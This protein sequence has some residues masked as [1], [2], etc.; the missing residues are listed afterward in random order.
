MPMA[1]TATYVLERHGDPS[2]IAALHATTLW[3]LERAVLQLDADAVAEVFTDVISLADLQ[4]P[5]RWR[6]IETRVLV[7]AA[8]RLPTWCPYIAYPPEA[9]EEGRPPPMRG[10]W[11]HREFDINTGR[12]E[13][14]LLVDI[15]GADSG[16]IASPIYLDRPTLGRAVDDML[17]STMAGG[18]QS[19]LPQPFSALTGNLIYGA[20]PLLLAAS[21]PGYLYPPLP[22][23]GGIPTHT[24]VLQ[25][26]R[27]GLRPIA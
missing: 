15:D 19:G 10:I 13:L 8:D 11:V 27:R 9:Q 21:R 22:A 12:P 26:H 18:D 4:D 1:A 2:H 6:S 23:Q 24:T 14:R 16:L 17:A 20:V 7:E 5:Q 25:Q 3:R